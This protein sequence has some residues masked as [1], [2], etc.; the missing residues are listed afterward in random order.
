MFAHQVENLLDKHWTVS[1][2][3]LRPVLSTNDPC[4]T[5][6]TYLLPTTVLPGSRA[7]GYS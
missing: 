2:Y 1:G 7:L 6:C 5:N 3:R 4:R